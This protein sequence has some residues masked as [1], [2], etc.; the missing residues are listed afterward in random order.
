MT[1]QEIEERLREIEQMRTADDMR[2][3]IR[4][5]RREI[6][7]ARLIYPTGVAS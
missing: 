2:L 1:L 7:R 5:L 3:A 6:E 4:A